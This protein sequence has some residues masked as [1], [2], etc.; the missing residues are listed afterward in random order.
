VAGNGI[1]LPE[2][3]I[4]FAAASTR[5][6]EQYRPAISNAIGEY[7]SIEG[8]ASGKE[9]AQRAFFLAADLKAQRDFDGSPS[10]ETRH[11]RERKFTMKLS[12]SDKATGEVHEVKGA[13]K[14]KAGELTNNPCLE[15][16]GRTEKNAGKVQNFVG[17][18]EKAAGE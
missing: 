10:I 13:I 14:Q 16:D 3:C 4:S 5:R 8:S 9:N 1:S 2:V 15:S 18:V 11:R 17:K 6:G 12:T 7:C